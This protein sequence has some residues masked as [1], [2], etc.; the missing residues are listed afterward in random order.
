MVIY[1]SSEFHLQLAACNIWRREANLIIFLMLFTLLHKKKRP[2]AVVVHSQCWSFECPLK[3]TR[4]SC[5]TTWCMVCNTMVDH[6][7]WHVILRM[8]AYTIIVAAPCAQF[9]TRMQKNHRTLA[10]SRGTWDQR[11]TE[12]WQQSPYTEVSQEL[13]FFSQEQWQCQSGGQGSELSCCCCAQVMLRGTPS[14]GT[15]WKTSQIQ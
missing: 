3:I 14:L 1:N 5:T 4:Y 15:S 12:K 6:V 13:H 2:A 9:C 11:A 7:V 10:D 8:K